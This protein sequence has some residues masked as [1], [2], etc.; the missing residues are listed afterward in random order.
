MRRNRAVAMRAGAA[1]GAVLA[2]VVEPDAPDDEAHIGPSLPDLRAVAPEEGQD[3]LRH[4]A[5]DHAG[6]PRALG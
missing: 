2:R 6:G 4:A 1:G 3:R 5:A